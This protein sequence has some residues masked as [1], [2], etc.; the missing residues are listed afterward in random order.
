M[1]SL[2][3]FIIILVII[4]FILIISIYFIYQGKKDIMDEE[5]NIKEPEYIEG[6]YITDKAIK[7]LDSKEEYFVIKDV[8]QQ[9]QTYI[10]YLDYDVTESRIKLENKEE[11]KQV[12]DEYKQEGID[13]IKNMMSNEYM[14]EFNIND[15]VIYDSLA[16]YANKNIT[17]ED[18][19][20]SESS[21]N[22]KTYFVYLD[23]LDT[24]EEFNLVI[25]IDSSNNSFNIMLKNYMDKMDIKKEN[26]IGKTVEQAIQ[27][28][29]IN[30]YNTYN[31]PD[32][33][34]ATYIQELFENYKTYLAILPN[35]AYEMLDNEFKQKRF[36]NIQNYKIYIDNYSSHLFNMELSK[37]KI[38]HYSDYTEYVCMNQYGNYLIFRE[39]KLMDYTVF[40]DSYTI[41]SIEFT[42]RYNKSDEQQKVAMNIE[43]VIFALNS[44]D[45]H[46]VYAKLEETFKKNNFDT[47]EKF[48]T[49]INQTLFER[50]VVEYDKF[51]KEG[52]TYMYQLKIKPSEENEIDLR[53]A[54]IIMK[55]LENNDYIISFNIQ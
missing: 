29:E 28:I 3:R 54:T 47:V 16:K 2:K 52:K 32:I 40:L 10:N 7:E 34:D 4:A 17:I 26:M 5:G 6:T 33:S 37:Y 12:I 1:K 44:K 39:K 46:Y 15:S 19:Y 23:V 55:L 30:E 36:G 31:I 51:L 13:S 24:D 22:I 50:N 35:K 43:K 49:Y 42:E 45:Y 53:N 11:E 9:V 38:N 14:Q 48:E 21:V 20:V 27:N 18:I 25:T 8:V 41:D